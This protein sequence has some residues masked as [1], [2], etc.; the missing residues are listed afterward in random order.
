MLGEIKNV[1][2]PLDEKI[3][4]STF[5]F[6]S[7]PSQGYI[8]YVDERWK[9]HQSLLISQRKIKIMKDKVKPRFI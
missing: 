7:K 5:V 1:M 8:G 9:C 3:D 2:K 4:Y 6:N